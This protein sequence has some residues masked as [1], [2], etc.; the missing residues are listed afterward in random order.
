MTRRERVAENINRALHGLLDD[1]SGAYVIGEDITDPYGGAFKVTKGLS[2]RHPDRVISSPLSEGGIVGVGAGLALTGN[3]PVIEMMFADFAALAFDQLLNFASKSVSMYGRRVPMSMVVRCPTGGNRGYGPTHSQSLQK[4]FIGI[5]GLSLYESSPFHDHGD[6][7]TAMLE[8]EQPCVLFEDKVLY[9]RT[10]HGDEV[11]DDL[12]RYEMTGEDNPTA[13]VFP[14]DCPDPDWILVA[15]G[16]LT[17][18]VLGAMRSLLL[19]E[20]LVCELLVP[21]RLYP[22]D[23]RPL[24]PVLSRA[25]RVC[26]VEDSTADGTWGELLA[27][28]VHE[29]LWGRLH[30][31][32]LL[33]SAEASIVP[34]AAHLER[35]VILQGSAIHRAIAEATQ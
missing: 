31:P 27:Q 14:L 6:V 20:E 26:V 24:L 33:L 19:E 10:M 16:G 7:F 12:F 30:R 13:R 15:P 8:R 9:T 28:Q 35:E 23:V 34:T 11:V 32:V 4:H 21:S 18:R 1:D 3:R 22:F 2:Q 29:Q 25:G 5:P 17:E